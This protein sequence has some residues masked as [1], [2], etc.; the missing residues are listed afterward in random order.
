MIYCYPLSFDCNLE[1]TNHFQRKD[2]EEEFLHAAENGD[3]PTIKTI[4][5]NHPDFNVDCE[6]IL[7]RTP[8]RLAV[9]SEHLQVDSHDTWIKGKSHIRF[10]M[11]IIEP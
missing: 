11:M 9:T 4:L 7:G 3:V 8:L 10:V 5:R 2:K 6:D 1:V